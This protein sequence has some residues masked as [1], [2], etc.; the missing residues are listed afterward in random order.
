[1][2]AVPFKDLASRRDVRVVRFLLPFY[3]SKTNRARPRS[4]RH[5]LPFRTLSPAQRSKRIPV[6][7]LVSR[8]SSSISAA[9]RITPDSLPC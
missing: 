3:F 8:L 4:V 6:R 7:S 9:R 5:R 1:M 2:R